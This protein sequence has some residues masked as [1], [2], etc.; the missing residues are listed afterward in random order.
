MNIRTLIA[1]M[2]LLAT[3][4]EPIRPVASGP[5]ATRPRRPRTRRASAR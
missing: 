1:L 5:S 4:P 2:M 3:D